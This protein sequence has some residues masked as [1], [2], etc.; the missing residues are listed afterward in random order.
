MLNRDVGKCISNKN[1]ICVAFDHFDNFS[2]SF[3]PLSDD[4]SDKKYQLSRP[5]LFSP[6]TFMAMFTDIF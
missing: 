4:T 5:C 2:V 3:S 6:V 1:T